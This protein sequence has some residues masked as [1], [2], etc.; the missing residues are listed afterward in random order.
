MRTN[1]DQTKNK[2]TKYIWSTTRVK[3]KYN[4]RTTQVQNRAQI[5][6]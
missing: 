4:E 6:K 5:I 2:K 1:R 3:T